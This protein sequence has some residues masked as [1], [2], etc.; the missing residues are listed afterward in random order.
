MEHVQDPYGEPEGADE[1]GARR[2]G[3]TLARPSRQLLLRPTIG[4]ALD[5]VVAARPHWG[6]SDSSVHSA[7][8]ALI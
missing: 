4:P 8:M 7:G 5:A 1:E 6:L 2:D 3:P